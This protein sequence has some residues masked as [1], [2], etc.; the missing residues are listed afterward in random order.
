MLSVLL[1]YTYS[2]C[3]VGI[4]KL[5]LDSNILDYHWKKWIDFLCA[6][7]CIPFIKIEH[8]V[9]YIHTM[10]IYVYDKLP[11][12][13]GN[14]FKKKHLLVSDSY[15]RIAIVLFIYVSYTNK[16]CLYQHILSIYYYWKCP[17]NNIVKTMLI[18][19]TQIKYIYD[20]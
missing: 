14:R 4:F 16:I 17:A 2:D 13:I 1:W 20:L 6:H 3:P 11:T 9:R 15:C 19:I 12:I 8:I 10:I 5:F 18:Y 7:F